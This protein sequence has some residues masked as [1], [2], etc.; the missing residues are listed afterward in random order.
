MDSCDIKKTMLYKKYAQEREHILR[1]KWYMSEK[2][3]YD[4]GYER[5]FLDW[6]INKKKYLNT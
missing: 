2:Y 3:G 1:N 4:V 6:L 5:A